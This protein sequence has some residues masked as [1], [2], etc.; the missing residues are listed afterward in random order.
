MPISLKQSWIR[1]LSY[2]LSYLPMCAGFIMAA[3]QPE[4]RALHDLI[5]GTVSIVKPTI[6][7]EEE[8]LNSPTR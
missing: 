4:K 5:A 7:P 1:C 8:D 6:Y 2:T 3:F